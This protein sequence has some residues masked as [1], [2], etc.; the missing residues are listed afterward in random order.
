MLMTAGR[1]PITEEGPPGTRDLY[2]HWAQES[3]DQGPCFA[4]T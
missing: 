2:I 1:T 4:S 3:F